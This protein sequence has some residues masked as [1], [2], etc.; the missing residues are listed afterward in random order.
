MQSRLFQQNG[1]KSIETHSDIKIICNFVTKTSKFLYYIAA[2][3]TEILR[4]LVILLQDHYKI[5]FVFSENKSDNEQLT[6]IHKA[7]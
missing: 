3:D 6:I 7:P 5:A 2:S 1:T 4:L